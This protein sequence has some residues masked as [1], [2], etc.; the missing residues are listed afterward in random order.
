[1][2][3]SQQSPDSAAITE[4]GAGGDIAQLAARLKATGDPLRLEILRLLS[5]DSYSVLELCRIFSLRQ[6]ALS[7]T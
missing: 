5:Q 6:P 4:K 7:T 3:Q 2:L 1:M